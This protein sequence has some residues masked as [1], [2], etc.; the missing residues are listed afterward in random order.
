MET[1]SVFVVVSVAKRRR[2]LDI[3]PRET[4]ITGERQVKR[5]MTVNWVW[6]AI[7]QQMG[8]VGGGAGGGGG[9]GGVDVIYTCCGLA[10]S[11][12]GYYLLRLVSQIQL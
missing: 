12:Y 11:R 3:M 2:R 1:T 7:T 8:D 10:A 4:S 5:P 9:G 6:R